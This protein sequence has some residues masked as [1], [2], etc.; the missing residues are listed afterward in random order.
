MEAAWAALGSCLVCS[1]EGIGVCLFERVNF[2][3][4]KA[5]EGIGFRI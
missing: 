5:L 2:L 4:K 3:K 1:K